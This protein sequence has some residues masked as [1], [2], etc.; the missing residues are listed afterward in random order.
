M[1]TRVVYQYLRFDVL[2]LG[3]ST[4]LPIEASGSSNFDEIRGFPD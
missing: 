2:I 4:E 3:P 1:V